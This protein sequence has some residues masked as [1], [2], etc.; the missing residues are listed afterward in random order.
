MVINNDKNNKILKYKIGKGYLENTKW[1]KH[2]DKVV[3]YGGNIQEFLEENPKIVESISTVVKTVGLCVSCS[4]GA[5]VG[6]A[7][8]AISGGVATA[9]IGG[10][11]AVPGAVIGSVAG[12]AYGMLA[13]L[14]L[15]DAVS[16]GINRLAQ[17]IT[18]YRFIGD[19]TVSEETK[20]KY[21]KKLAG[22]I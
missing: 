17:M 15:D 5:A 12:C 13:N 18:K 7:R 19:N 21:T 3:Q 10:E 9:P 4:S 22:I 8:G 6:A 1:V 14:I 16:L 11:G 2:L 20:Q